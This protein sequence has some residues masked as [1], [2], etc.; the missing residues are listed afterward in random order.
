MLKKIKIS[1]FI[2]IIT[3]FIISCSSMK[4]TSHTDNKQIVEEI[5]DTTSNFVTIPLR[6]NLANFEFQ[7]EATIFV[8]DNEV[9]GNIEGGYVDRNQLILNVFGPFGIHIASIEVKQDTLRIANLWHKRYY[10]TKVEIK[11]EEINLSLL[12]LA[13]KIII[14]E[15]L[16]DKVTLKKISDTLNFEHKFVNG[17][18]NY[19][20]FLSKN[21]LNFKQLNVEKY[22]ISLKYSQYKKIG[23]NNYPFTIYIEVNEVKTK[24]RLELEDI[25]D[26][27]DFQKYK[28]IDYSKLQKVDEINK[29]AK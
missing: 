29:L 19:N 15:P 3:I 26:L 23:T 11:A 12:E 5:K 25:K 9:G 20:Y 8:N 28:P 27:K 13:R 10:Q 17:I 6:K 14:A 2:V 24:I 7:G 1:I 4:D 21:S 16:V 22:N 18:A